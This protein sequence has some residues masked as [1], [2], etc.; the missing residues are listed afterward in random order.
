MKKIFALSA[1]YLVI[2]IAGT[3]LGT[4]LYFL[5]IEGISYVA[6]ATAAAVSLSVL[7]TGLIAAFPVVLMFSSLLL[8]FFMLR[9]PLPFY[10]AALF[11]VFGIVTWG[12]LFPLGIK[13]LKSLPTDSPAVIKEMYTPGF[14][15]ESGSYVYYFTAPGDSGKLPGVRYAIN[16]I[17]SMNRLNPELI[18]ATEETK[19]KSEFNDSLAEKMLHPPF[20]VQQAFII[21]SLPAQI[22]KNCK[23][24]SDYLLFLS[25]GAA[26]IM[27]GA[28]KNI[29]HWRLINVL[30]SATITCIIFYLNLSYYEQ[31]RLFIKMISPL[32]PFIP[33]GIPSIVVINSALALFCIGAGL[34]SMFF[35]KRREK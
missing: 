31:N 21:F 22:A 30:N 18:E 13:A 17:N 5:Y 3:L 35:N 15:R 6:G 26:L 23:S 8:I 33:E 12:V 34:L 19:S 27:V 14:F 16:G 28:V 10:A 29:S 24:R 4:I 25:L 9:H 20:F 1:T 11:Y 32:Q 2:C 7:K